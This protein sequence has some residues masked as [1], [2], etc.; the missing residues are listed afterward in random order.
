MQWRHCLDLGP[1]VL[2]RGGAETGA[3]AGRQLDGDHPVRP[4][5]S[6]RCHFLPE[7]AD[8]AFQVGEGATS[9]GVHGRREHDVR[10]GDARRAE[11][12]DGDDKA[13]AVQGLRCQLTVRAVRQRI[14][15]E[16]EE[17]VELPGR[18]PG[19]H[20]QGVK[21]GRRGQGCPPVVLVPLAAVLQP[22][23]SRQ[24]AR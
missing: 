22:D 15:P 8:A 3:K 12:V 1:E 7:P 18:R 11:G 19:E 6:G 5:H 20:A 16:E 24:Q 9:F 13:G 23:A 2:Q 21:P 17:D 10:P 4:G 14:G